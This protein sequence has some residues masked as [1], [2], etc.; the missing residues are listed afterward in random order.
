MEAVI[1]SHHWL[2]GAVIVPIIVVFISRVRKS[3]VKKATNTVGVS[4][5]IVESNIVEISG[6]HNKL[7][8]LHVGDVKNYVQE[9]PN[10]DK[11]VDNFKKYMLIPKAWTRSEHQDRVEY[12]YKDDVE[13]T[14]T[15]KVRDINTPPN[16]YFKYLACFPDPN[17]YWALSCEL[18]Y[19][20]KIIGKSCY[21]AEGDGGRIILPMADDIY[22]FDTITY[23]LVNLLNGIK[24]LISGNDWKGWTYSQSYF[25]SVAYNAVYNLIKGYYD[26][27]YD[28]DKIDR[29]ERYKGGLSEQD[30]KNIIKLF[31]RPP[32]RII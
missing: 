10:H 22:D 23:S 12:I 26:S 11:V 20:N 24:V 13:Y 5:S 6:N 7:K 21:L 9:K 32:K 25:K 17:N 4:P 3:R 16:L 31:D 29:I 27:L 18:L 28:H 8:N 19:K 30:I 1:A 14:V 2:I 15:T